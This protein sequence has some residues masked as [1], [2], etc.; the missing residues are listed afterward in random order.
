[1]NW[2][3]DNAVDPAL[4]PELEPELQEALLNFRGSVHAWSGEVYAQ[5]RR[6]MAVSRHLSW[7]VALG[8]AMASLLAAGTLGGVYLHQRAMVRHANTPVA[9]AV[10]RAATVAAEPSAVSG[11]ASADERKLDEAAWDVAAIQDLLAS[12]DRQARQDV[13]AAG[14]EQGEVDLLAEV[15]SDVERRAPRAMEPLQ[16][17]MDESETQ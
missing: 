11:G 12:D 2:K 7:R 13:Q 10:R 1:M 9:A 14:G 6:A 17:L 15:N 4:A 5:P 8:G 3:R 16:R